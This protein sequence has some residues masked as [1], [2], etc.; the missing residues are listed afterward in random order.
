MGTSYIS[1]KAGVDGAN[2]GNIFNM[3]YLP[4]DDI[5]FTVSKLLEICGIPHTTDFIRDTLLTHPDYP[6]LLSLSES[7]LEWGIESNAVKGTIRDL[8]E[9]DYPSIAYLKN[10]RYVVLESIK[11]SKVTVIFPV[12]GRLILTM[13]DF[14]KA[15]S[16][17]ILRVSPS[18]H[19]G[20]KD[21]RLHR[22]NHL[23]KKVQQFLAFP[24][25]FLFG[26][27]A[28]IYKTLNS[29]ALTILIPLGI[30]K[31]IG[32]SVCVAL[33]A[34]HTGRS[35]IF[36]SICPRG[37][38]SNCHR[39]MDSPAARILGIPMADLGILYF[40][41]GFLVLF[42]SLLSGQLQSSLFTLGVLSVMLLPYTF[43]SIAYQAFV[44]H[45]WCRL[46]LMVQIISW[47][48]F[49]LFYFIVFAAPGEAGWAPQFPA[50]F[51]FGTVL[52]LWLVLR[53]IFKSYLLRKDKEVEVTRM[54]SQPDFIGLQLSKAQK[55]D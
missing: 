26:L 31:L 28:F 41:G 3:N 2:L 39:V 34:G 23:L 8:S 50:L 37:K 10:N 32:L 47:I 22:R 45:S 49:A 46:C 13:D 52:L 14:N 36:E 1:S 20:E 48:E 38:M 53:P 11:D 7:L 33:F 44:I 17:I 9:A 30:S 25:F 21:F 12:K 18:E 29:N 19:V 16:G 43:F 27:A 55:T 5:A 51:G 4:D 15:W 40:S 35:R 54:Y 6:S 42:L 24:G